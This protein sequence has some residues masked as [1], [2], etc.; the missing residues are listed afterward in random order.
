M[1]GFLY[2]K[3]GIL[4][5]NDDG[6]L[7][8]GDAETP[9]PACCCAGAEPCAS[10]SASTPAQWQVEFTGVVEG[11]CGNCDL[12]NTTTFILTQY[13]ACEWRVNFDH[14]WPL[15]AS[16]GGYVRL[17]V[18]PTQV[19]VDVVYIFGGIP[20]PARF[21]RG[22]GTDCET[23]LNP[24]FQFQSGSINCAFGAASCVATPL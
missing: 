10:C 7:K 4:L 15:T 20:A 9:D 6:T 19:I 8:S 5:A 21:R 12:F 3:D 2:Q 18:E 22:S 24:A 17:S 11:T 16:T 1:A 23:V 13:S 14:C